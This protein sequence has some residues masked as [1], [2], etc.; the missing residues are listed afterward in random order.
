MDK[1]IYLAAIAGIATL[2]VF[3]GCG[4]EAD[5]TSILFPTPTEIEQDEDF[6]F[7][8]DPS[9]ELS[10]TPSVDWQTTPTP[11]EEAEPDEDGNLPD[12]GDLELMNTP[13]PEPRSKRLF[14]SKKK[15]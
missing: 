9:V 15:Q 8:F 7:E 6:D 2:I 10:V 11:T 5:D 14:V 13:I 3:G 1:K 12:E 4:Q